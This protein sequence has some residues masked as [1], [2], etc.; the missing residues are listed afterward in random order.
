S[1]VLARGGRPGLRI[2]P[3]RPGSRPASARARRR[4]N[5]IWALVLRSSSAAHRARASW[6]AGSSRS[7][8]LFRSLTVVAVPASLV[9]GAGVDDLLGRLLAAQ[10]DEQVGDHGRLALLIEVDDALVLEPLEG[11]LDHADRALDD[12]PPRADHRVGL[13]LAEH[14]LGD[15]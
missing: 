5:S 13:L 11:Q 8:M 14:G 2:S 10:H 6:T 12:P 15:L 1:G 9:E 7:R 4:R 3:T